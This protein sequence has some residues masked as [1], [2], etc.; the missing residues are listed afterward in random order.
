M[1][2]ASFRSAPAKPAGVLGGPS[3][4]Q[5]FLVL[6][7]P[8]LDAPVRGL[9]RWR[10]VQVLGIPADSSFQFLDVFDQF[11]DDFLEARYQ[12]P[13]RSRGSL[14]LFLWNA[15]AVA[16]PRLGWCGRHVSATPRFAAFH[17]PLADSLCFA[18]PKIVSFNAPSEHLRANKQFWLWQC[19]SF[20]PSKGQSPQW[21]RG[22]H[23]EPRRRSDLPKT[24]F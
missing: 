17:P 9:G 22:C 21:H 11:S 6:R 14:P 1:A 20:P 18:Q 15:Q 2:P 4:R 5:A 23:G 7:F 10:P 8:S 24:F 13:H 3:L 12:G 16:S 19:P